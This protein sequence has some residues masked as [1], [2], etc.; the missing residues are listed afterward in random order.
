MNSS[1]P[2]KFKNIASV[3]GGILLLQLVGVLFIGLGRATTHGLFSVLEKIPYFEE[4]FIASGLALLA[5]GVGISSY[6][7]GCRTNTSK[8]NI[9]KATMVF[10]V[11][12]FFVARL[13]SCVDNFN[14]CLNHSAEIQ[15]R[16]FTWTFIILL[17]P[18][19][20]GFSKKRKDRKVE[21]KRNREE[22]ES[23][24]KA[25]KQKF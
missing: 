18:Y 15:I 3:I 16:L 24:K 5:V 2:S 19:L 10:F 23:L 1:K 25:M 14:V 9:I 11:V 4:I 13:G 22:V 21:L 8:R 7:F 12:S 6:Y 17:V 20:I